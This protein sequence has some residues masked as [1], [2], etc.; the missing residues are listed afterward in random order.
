MPSAAFPI[1]ECEVSD[2]TIASYAKAAAELH[3]VE[4]LD[5][6]VAFVEIH[7]Y[8]GRVGYIASRYVDGRRG[9]EFH[10]ELMIWMR[11][12]GVVDTVCIGQFRVYERDD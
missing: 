11:C 8:E 4:F 1:P 12:D 6:D 9:V 10:R 3:D 2:S 5:D 7:R